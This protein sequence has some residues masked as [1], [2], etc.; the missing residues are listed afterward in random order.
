MPPA[1]IGTIE[2]EHVRIMVRGDDEPLRPRQSD[3]EPREV[4]K[5]DAMEAADIYD[6]LNVANSDAGNTK[7]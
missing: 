3:V 6:P 4:R 2:T 7:Q 1:L 5:L